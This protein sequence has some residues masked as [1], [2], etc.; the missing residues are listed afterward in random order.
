MTVRLKVAT[1]DGSQ[2]W[3]EFKDPKSILI[4][5]MER[6]DIVDID[7][8]PLASNSSLRSFMLTYNALQ[9]ID[10]SPLSTC[11]GLESVSLWK[12][13]LKRIDLSPLSK[14]ENLS[15]LRLDG[16]QLKKIDLS[17]LSSNKKL[18][19]INLSENRLKK[20][21]LSPLSSCTELKVLNLDR[22]E[23]R[24]INLSPVSSCSNL[25]T[26]SLQRNQL[27]SIDLSLL[28]AC[29]NLRFYFL[30]GNQLKEIDLSPLSARTDIEYVSINSNQLESIDL[31]P[32]KSCINLGSIE[33]NGNRLQTIDISP[34]SS[35]I[36]LGSIDLSRNRLQTID[37]SPLSSIR[38]IQTL[39]LSD[40]ML[41]TVDLSP[42]SSCPHFQELHLKGDSFEGVDITPLVTSPYFYYVETDAPVTSWIKDPF[43]RSLVTRNAQMSG[44]R[45]RFTVKPPAPARAWELLH[46][47]AN[48]PHG[49]SIPIQ[50]Y[51]LKALGLEKYGFI[52]ADISEFLCSIPSELSL[53]EARERVKPFLIEQMC[54][55]IDRG[56]TTI[57]L[58]VDRV[59]TEAKGIAKRME[60]IA[61]LRG[62]EM[63]QVVARR[64]ES[65]STWTHDLAHLYLTAYG[66][67]ILNSV[68]P[69]FLHEVSSSEFGMIQDSLRTMGYEIRTMGYEMKVVDA[70][71][72]TERF[73]AENMSI[74]MK[75][76][77]SNLYY[78]NKAEMERQEKDEAIQLKNALERALKKDELRAILQEHNIRFEERW[79]KHFLA[80]EIVKRM[81]VAF[82]RNLLEEVG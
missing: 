60:S 75:R 48:I 14:C 24:S 5:L 82:V 33:L 46:K 81:G 35:C 8:S 20:I 61:K 12:N 15:E 37:I 80:K 25:E 13:Q 71:D 17:P 67:S 18:E 39:K 55:Q 63:Q 16:N 54:E 52:D 34:L 29:P 77:V 44:S 59:F 70:K 51:I 56:G 66:F 65:Q 58:D 73:P 21:D 64:K 76:Y 31:T 11:K 10:L 23:L 1:I 42:L 50:T 45:E 62:S 9:S 32:L 49:L 6:R 28:T 53:D 26:L 40:N 3:M 72:I 43:Q 22:N 57:G 4:S 27:R 69:I 41:K 78:C 47:L 74:H 38:G 30:S 36:N 68:R 79:S 19:T 2:G 7:L